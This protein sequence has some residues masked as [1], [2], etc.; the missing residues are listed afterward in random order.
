M[1]LYQLQN[2][3]D[4]LTKKDAY[5]TNTMYLVSPKFEFKD[6]NKHEHWIEKIKI[7]KSALSQND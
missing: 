6:N 5:D 4:V 3:F 1:T 7:D 2:S